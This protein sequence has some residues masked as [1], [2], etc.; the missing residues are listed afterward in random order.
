MWL[1]SK[2]LKNKLPNKFWNCKIKKKLK[3]LLFQSSSLLRVVVWF[4]FIRACWYVWALCYQSWNSNFLKCVQVTLFV[5]VMFVRLQCMHVL[6][7]CGLFLFLSSSCFARLH[8]ALFYETVLIF[9]FRN[10]GKFT[11]IFKICKRSTMNYRWIPW[12]I[13]PSI[14]GNLNGKRPN[15][16][17]CFSLFPFVQNCCSRLFETNKYGRRLDWVA[18]GSCI[19]ARFDWN[20]IVQPLVDRWCSSVGHFFDRKFRRCLGDHLAT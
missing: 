5:S 7:L 14:H 1:E 20:Q 4:C 13:S 19:G 3:S 12:K 16:Y 18:I 17:S 6:L 9:I 10:F 11:F 2:S 8:V 15:S